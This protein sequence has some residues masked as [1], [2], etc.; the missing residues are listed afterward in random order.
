MATSSLD[1]LKYPIGPFTF[2]EQYD[3]AQVG[4]RIARIEQFP[5]QF[6]A[7][8]E[9][10][11]EAQLATSYREGGWTLRQLVH[12]VADSHMNAQ[13]RF[14]WALTEDTPTIKAYRQPEWALLPDARGPVALSLDLLDS[15]HARWV[16]LLRHMTPADYQKAFFHPQLKR[17]V[18]LY[19]NL[20]LYAWHGAHHLAHVKLVVA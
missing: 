2:P 4:E 11:T 1:S 6:R 16:Y 3:P 8:V 18:A 9:R 7:L 15:L 14:K 17:E 10:A 12:H 5:A 19:Q 13:V 20:A